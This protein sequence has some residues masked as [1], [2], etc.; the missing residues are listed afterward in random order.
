MY[1]ETHF[2]D[3]ELRQRIRRRIEGGQL[4]VMKSQSILAGYGM[5]HRCAACDHEITGTQVEYEVETPSGPVRFH[6]GCHVAWQLECV[7]AQQRAE[8]SALLAEGAAR[9]E[10]WAL[11]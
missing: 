8:D 1:T 11:W 2:W 10:P 4:P 5:G 7:R 3:T 6:L 9:R